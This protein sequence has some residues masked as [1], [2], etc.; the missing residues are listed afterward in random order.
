M[1]ADSSRN[2]G[3]LASRLPCHLI[4]ETLHVPLHGASCGQQQHRGNE[5]DPSPT[6]PATP[7]RDGSAK[8]RGHTHPVPSRRLTLFLIVLAGHN[9]TARDHETRPDGF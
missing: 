4:L 6:T 7:E 8:G 2:W 5:K 1:S 9:L 3:F